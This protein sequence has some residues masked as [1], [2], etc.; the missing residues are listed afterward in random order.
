MV[1]VVLEAPTT[2]D[3]QGV[4]TFTLLCTPGDDRA[5]ATG[6]LL[7]EGIIDGMADLTDLRECSDDP[8]VIRVK[9]ARP[10]D[11]AKVAGRNLLIVSSC[12]LCGAEDLEE[13]LQALSRVG[14]SLRIAARTLRSVGSRLRDHQPLFRASGGTHAAEIFT[15]SGEIVSSA[16]DAGR[17][18]ALDKAIGRCLLAG[19]S[20]AGCGVA[21]SGRVSLEMVIKCARAGIEIVSAVS[22]PTSLAIEV[23]ERC[24]ITLCAF[25]RETRASIFTHPGRI[26]CQGE[27]D[28]GPEPE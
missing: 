21:L 12:G 28:R 18:N 4:G 10:P 8:E 3:V 15:A 20:A 13:K 16:E 26:T 25:V 19:G 11:Q 1:S 27:G 23:A 24:G 2:V 17:H 5:L 14:D 22:A 7:S 9:L 6:F